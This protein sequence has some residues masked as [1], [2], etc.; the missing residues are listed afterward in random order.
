VHLSCVIAV[1]CVAWVVACGRRQSVS[2]TSRATMAKGMVIDG[3][4]DTDMHKVRIRLHDVMVY[5][6]S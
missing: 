3:G 4:W 6:I 1:C 5:M 2:T